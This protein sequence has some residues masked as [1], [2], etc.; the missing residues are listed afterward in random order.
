ML[1]RPLKS[2]TPLLSPRSPATLL[3]STNNPSD[4]HSE[5]SYHTLPRLYTPNLTPP[6]LNLTPPQTSHLKVLRLKPPTLIRCFDGKTGEHL[7]NLTSLTTGTILKTLLP[8]PPPPPSVT[9]Y[10]PPLKKKRLKTLIEKS[11]ELSVTSIKI[12]PQ[13]DYSSH[14]ITD[15][16][17]DKLRL[18][19]ESTACQCETFHVPKLSVTSKNFKEVCEDV[20]VIAV[21]RVCENNVLEKFLEVE[22]EF[23]KIFIGPEG[24][25]SHEERELFKEEK[26]IT[27]G[28]KVMRAE[29]A[30][31]YCLSV[32]NAVRN[33]K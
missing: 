33:I 2:F 18:T 1:L 6:T 10:T 19:I 26:C 4:S 28:E 23:M 17:I 24:G 27:L 30:G 31:I 13:T 11:V 15:K 3:F 20:D 21:E 16:Q 7:I 8:Q 22:E 32:W 29:T 9:L 12:V 5:P 25:W 14:K